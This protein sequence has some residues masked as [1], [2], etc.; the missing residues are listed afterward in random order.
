MLIKCTHADTARVLLPSALEDSRDFHLH[1][2]L[3]LNEEE[4]FA[5]MHGTDTTTVP[6]GM[7]LKMESCFHFP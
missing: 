7:L 4:D 1:I 6:L 5:E 3:P 2:Y